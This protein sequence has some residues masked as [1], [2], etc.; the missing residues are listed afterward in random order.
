MSR[1]PELTVL[2]LSLSLSPSVSVCGATVRCSRPRSA[3]PPETIGVCV[4]WNI[5]DDKIQSETY[6]CHA[7]SRA[8]LSKKISF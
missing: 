5:R 3:S 6:N 4:K 2:S 1:L 8:S 7:P